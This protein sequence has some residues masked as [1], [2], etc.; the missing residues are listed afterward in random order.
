MTDYDTAALRDEIRS[1]GACV[2]ELNRAI[3]GVN[4]RLDSLDN[5]IRFFWFGL[6]APMPVF[7]PLATE[8]FA[9]IFKR[10]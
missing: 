6:W 7:L 2:S 10:W 5:K 8:I 4:Q 1:L 9:T 3:S